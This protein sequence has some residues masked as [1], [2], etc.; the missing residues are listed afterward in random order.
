[1]TPDSRRLRVTI[2]GGAGAWRVDVPPRGPLTVE[3]AAAPVAVTRID[4]TT[5]QAVVDGRRIP[6]HVAD[7][8]ADGGCR[9][10]TD[11]CAF[12]FDVNDHADADHADAGVDANADAAGARPP[13]VQ[14]E[15]GPALAA[16][17][18]ATV[19]ATPAERG[20]AVRAGD[21]LVVL[22][23]MKME[24]TIRAHRD[25]VIDALHCRRGDLVQPGV[26]LVTLRPPRGA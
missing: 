1:M 18:P 22:D 2:R 17:M 23:A 4:R 7:T 5:Y 13:G 11:G 24:L 21:V 12:T 3:G 19:V 15:S 26:P 6:V 8:G 25:G 9:L 14:P 20:Q 16:P 10:F